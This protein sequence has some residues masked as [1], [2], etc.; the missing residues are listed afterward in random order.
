MPLTSFDIILVDA[1]DQEI[2]VGEK[3]LVHEKGLL[4]RAFSVCILREGKTGIEL[5]IQQRHMEKYHSGGLWSNTCCGHP[6]PGQI[7]KEAAEKRLFEEMGIQA[8]LQEVGTFTYKAALDNSLT[9]HEL[10]HVFVGYAHD[11]LTINPHPD[12]VMDYKWMA[13]CELAQDIQT[14]PKAYTA[15]LP[16]VVEFLKML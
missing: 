13:L 8:E 9:E 12:E 2:G 4:H 16:P 10:D 6:G 11:N 15:W 7:T 14:H 3:L 5:L 1:N